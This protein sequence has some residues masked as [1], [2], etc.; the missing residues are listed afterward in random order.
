MTRPAQLTGSASLRRFV[1]RTLGVAALMLAGF[2]ALAE[3]LEAQAAPSAPP[4]PPAAASAATAAPVAPPA[5]AAAMDAVSHA[6]ALKQGR[7]TFDRAMTANIE[8]LLQSAD[9]ALGGADALR[10]RLETGLKQLAEQ[11]GQEVSMSSEKVMLVN[12]TVQ[13]WRTGEYAQVPVPIVF[14]VI[15][16]PSGWRGF[17]ANA[18]EQVPPGKEILP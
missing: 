9:S 13:Y 16:G 10:P 17:T 6:E 14:R 1:R 8:A 12:G 11:L 4:T 2:I 5:P 15:V 7:L 3:S 18:E